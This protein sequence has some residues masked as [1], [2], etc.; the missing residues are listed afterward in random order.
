VGNSDAAILSREF[1][2][3]LPPTAFVDLPR[4]HK[5]AKIQ[6]ANEPLPTFKARLDS[7]TGSYNDTASPKI[8]LS[9][10][11]YA[12]KRSTVEHKIALWIRKT[13]F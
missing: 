10:I 13:E 7:V 5:L 12:E 9:R 1:G 4:F 2:N 11:R 3:E 8:A 6:E